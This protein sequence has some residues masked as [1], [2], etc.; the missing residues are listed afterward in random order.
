MLELPQHHVGAQRVSV[1][2]LAAIADQTSGTRLGD[3][4]DQRQIVVGRRGNDP[5]APIGTRSWSYAFRPRLQGY[6]RRR[7]AAGPGLSIG[8]TS[9]CSLDQFLS[10][11][12]LEIA[13]HASCGTSDDYAARESGVPI[14]D[15]A[16]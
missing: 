6:Q 12:I 14:D 15:G 3:A 7:Q 16:C 2:R 8:S 10:A 5:S 4:L 1:P 11:A 13:P 9:E